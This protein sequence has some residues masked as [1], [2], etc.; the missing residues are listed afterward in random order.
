MEWTMIGIESHICSS[1]VIEQAYSKGGFKTFTK[2]NFSFSPMKL[3][4]A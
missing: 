3:R 4:N 1:N 2:A